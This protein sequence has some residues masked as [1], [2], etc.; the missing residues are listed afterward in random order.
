MQPNPKILGAFVVGLAL[1]GGSYTISSLTRPTTLTPPTADPSVY[2]VAATAPERSFIEVVDSDQ[3]GIEDWQEEFAPQTP[4]QIDIEPQSASVY[5]VP[6]T[7]TDQMS[8]QLFQSVLRA[9][10]RGNVGPTPEQVVAETTDILRNTVIRDTIYNGSMITVVE[11]TPEAIRAWGNSLG[12]SLSARNVPNSEGELVIID[13][14]MKTENP[15]EL[16]KLEPL[17]AM[18]KAL[19]DDALAT[20]VPRGFEKQHLDLINVYQ[21]MF[22]SLDGLK[23]AFKDPVVSLLR[24][25]RYQDDATGLAFAL[26]NI[27]NVL[28]PHVKVFN[29]NDPVYVFV[30]FSPQ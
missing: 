19:R 22:A 18:Y 3:N 12:S 11:N 16:E 2:T 13:R 8:I 5:E 7:V 26:Q 20:P 4:L 17:I 30:A 14:A 28:I 15:A 27:Y 6:N 1:V 21:A 24:V 10:G 23:L 25:K 9:K 29:Q